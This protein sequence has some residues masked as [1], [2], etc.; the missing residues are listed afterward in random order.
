MNQH[1]AEEMYRQSQQYHHQMRLMP[2]IEEAEQ[3]L[4]KLVDQWEAPTARE[5]AEELLA[6]VRLIKQLRP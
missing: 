3:R 6:V 4:A 5:V 1:S 2:Q